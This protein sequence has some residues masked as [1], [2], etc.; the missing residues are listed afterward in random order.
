MAIIDGEFSR[1]MRPTL[2]ATPS[3]KRTLLNELIAPRY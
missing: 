1:A 2:K 3:A